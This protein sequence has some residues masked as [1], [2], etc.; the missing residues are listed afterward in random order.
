MMR[1]N[2][3]KQKE[4]NKND[5]FFGFI[6]SPEYG[7]RKNEIRGKKLNKIVGGQQADLEDWGW[8]K[9]N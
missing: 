1:N 4:K 9:L 5:A 7:R 2:E 6:N 3:D 8:Q